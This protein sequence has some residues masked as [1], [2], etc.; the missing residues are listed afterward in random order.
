[1]A[2]T[3]DDFPK[4]VFIGSHR[5]YV[6][7][8]YERFRRNYIAKHQ[9]RAKRGHGFMPL[10]RTCV[11]NADGGQGKTYL[12]LQLEVAMRAKIPFL[13][14]PVKQG[15]VLFFSAEEPLQILR[16]R[17]EAI[18]LAEGLKACDLSGLHVLDHSRD[19]AWLFEEDRRTGQLRE[20]ERFRWLC[21]L[22][23]TIQPAAL[24][25]DNRARI[26]RGNQ[27]DSGLATE[28]IA[29]LDR[30]AARH[31]MSILLLSHPSLSGIS[32]GRGDS[33]SVAWSNAARARMYL[34]QP[35]EDARSGPDDGKRVLTSM[36]SSHGQQGKSVNLQW[37]NGRFYCDY[38]PPKADAGTLSDGS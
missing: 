23:E 15:P 6:L 19:V 35:G 10:G 37:Q 7:Q 13:G 32:S 22:V 11:L 27:N 20:T 9:G 18:C 3:L 30:L 8:D 29:I 26:F 34:H 12:A 4:P 5:K 31:D 17:I 28:V 36:K 38:Q 1:M 24:V 14:L 2:E 16:Y 33:G 21:E 25:L